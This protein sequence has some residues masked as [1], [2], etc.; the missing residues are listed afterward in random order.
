MSQAGT[1][2]SGSGG[3]TVVITPVSTFQ[4]NVVLQEF[5]DFISSGG[6]STLTSK[7]IWESTNQDMGYSVGTADHPGIVTNSLSG[8]ASTNAAM[9]ARQRAPGGSPTIDGPYVLG[10][11][12]TSVSWI[13]KLSSLSAG[14]N[15]YRFSCGLADATTIL[16]D[17]DAFVNGVY[18]QY[19]NTVNAGQWT[20]NCTSASATT[21]VST[22]VVVATSWTTL[23]ILTNAA[24]TSVSF[25]VNNVLAGTAI[26]TNIPTS[27]ITAFMTAINTAG[28][29]PDFSA[30]LYYIDIQLTNPRPG[31]TFSQAVVGTGM[32]I[33]KYTATPISYQVLNSDAIIGVTST[34]AARTIT[35]P[36]SSLVTG[37]VW[38]IKDESGG[39][40][41]NNITVSGNGKNIDD[42]AT[43]PISTNYGSVSLYYNGTQFYLV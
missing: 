28:T 9:Y 22:A 19:T 10:G 26:T 38:T 42:A 4:P 36:A 35:M 27:E 25:Y 5:D 8:A 17:S 23:T 32:L 43:Y 39:A 15:T 14:G 41:V 16:A 33:E 34:A 2:N 18:F 31:P 11:G 7:L 6:S 24:G 29:T 37:Q 12:A 3:G 1:T 30:D 20:I 40:S 13:V 21:T